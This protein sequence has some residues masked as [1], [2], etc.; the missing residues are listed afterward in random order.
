MVKSKLSRFMLRLKVLTSS[1]KKMS[2]VQPKYIPS[3]F[4]LRQKTY[5]MKAMS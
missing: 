3:S 1:S 5:S 2:R 4:N